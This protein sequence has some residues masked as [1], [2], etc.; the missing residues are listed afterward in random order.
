MDQLDRTKST[1]IISPTDFLILKK[2]NPHNHPQ[3]VTGNSASPD[4]WCKT[5]CFPM[6]GKSLSLAALRPDG[7]Q[8]GGIVTEVEAGVHGGEDKFSLKNHGMENQ[9]KR[10]IF[11]ENLAYGQSYLRMPFPSAIMNIPNNIMP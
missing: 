8:H 9:K 2:K 1:N 6:S 5:L 11:L 7:P 3:N 10:D 4:N